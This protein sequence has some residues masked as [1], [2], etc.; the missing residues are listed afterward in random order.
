LNIL[1][2]LRPFQLVTGRTWK[3]TAFGGFKSRPQVPQLVDRYMRGEAKRDEY[4]THTL[5]FAKINE[6]LE[7]L[8]GA[9]VEYQA[10]RGR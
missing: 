2:C 8:H 3:G 9:H 10:N 6:G 4:V 1:C 7:L 5:P